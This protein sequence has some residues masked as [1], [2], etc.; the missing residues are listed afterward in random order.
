MH[1]SEQLRPHGT[2]SINWEPIPISEKPARFARKILMFFRFC[3]RRQASSTL[4]R[5]RPG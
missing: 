4:S 3:D 2:T 5:R 1:C